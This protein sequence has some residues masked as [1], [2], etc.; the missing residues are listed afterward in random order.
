[1]KADS[2]P[3]DS[4]PPGSSVSSLFDRLA[5]LGAIVLDLRGKN[6]DLEVFLNGQ[7]P[8]S[9][10]NGDQIAYEPDTTTPGQPAQR[11]ENDGEPG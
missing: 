10:N 1:M 7:P 6:A 4:N 3:P 11:G 5:D 2:N 8:I 9:L